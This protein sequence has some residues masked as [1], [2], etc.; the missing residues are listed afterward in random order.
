M[1][2]FLSIFDHSQVKVGA[3]G[4]ARSGMIS[5]HTVLTVLVALRGPG[6][7]PGAIPGAAPGAGRERPAVLFIDL[8][9]RGDSARPGDSHAGNQ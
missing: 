8:H 3:H 1:F 5:V 2:F 7:V 6:A 4:R 9:G